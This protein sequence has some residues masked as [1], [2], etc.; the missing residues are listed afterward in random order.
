MKISHKKMVRLCN[1]HVAGLALRF[2][3]K[4]D[5]PAAAR[6]H[7][8]GRLKAAERNLLVKVGLR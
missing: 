1:E 3:L 7:E 8:E 4:G 6:R 2:L 5:I